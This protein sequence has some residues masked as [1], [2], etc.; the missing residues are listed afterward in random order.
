MQRNSIVARAKSGPVDS[1][2]QIRLADDVDWHGPPPLVPPSSH[3]ALRGYVE[4]LANVELTV[5]YL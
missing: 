1:H 2:R 4:E 3:P 5:T